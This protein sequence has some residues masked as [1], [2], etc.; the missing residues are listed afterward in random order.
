MM[1]TI[2]S[3]LVAFLKDALPDVYVA[4]DV[5]ADRPD[6]FITLERTGGGLDNVVR[7]T[8]TV[9]IQAWAPTRA[10]AMALAEDVR[11][12]MDA[13]KYAPYICRCSLNGMY[14]YPTS[15]AEPRYQLVYDIVMRRE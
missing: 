12:A 10:E 8:P 14:N 1:T 5:P 2:E 11:D 15:H 9:A 6:Y 7:D 13:F 4:A 3:E